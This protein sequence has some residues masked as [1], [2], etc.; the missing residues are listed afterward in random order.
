M[1]KKKKYSRENGFRT[2][3]KARAFLTAPQKIPQS[4][5]ISH[6]LIALSVTE[7]TF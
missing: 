4:C 1:K 3:K 6:T 2:R 5:L 7:N